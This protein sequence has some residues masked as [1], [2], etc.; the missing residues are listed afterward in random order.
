MVRA[1]VIGAALLTGC[2]GA[3]ARRYAVT[4]TDASVISCGAET[5]GLSLIDQESL[6][7]AAAKLQKEWKRRAQDN[8]PRAVAR[9][10]LISETE[11]A[12][13]AWL[14]EPLVTYTS[15]GAT[16]FAGRDEVLTGVPHD[17]YI[18]VEHALVINTDKADK[19]ADR[20]LCGD[21]TFATS[22]LLAT[23]D[24]GAVE[25]RLRRVEIWYPE[26][27]FFSCVARISCARNIEAVGAEVAGP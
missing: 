26:T 22:T 8:P 6:E 9:E 10:L 25:G 5:G 23:E 18:D 14:D 1:V 2:G 3:E 15:L 17:D 13:Q 20:P 12:V 27:L 4:L 7:E 11:E 16:Y 19:D 24:G 21:R